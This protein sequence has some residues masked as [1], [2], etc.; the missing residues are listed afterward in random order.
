[1]NGKKT[2]IPFGIFWNGNNSFLGAGG[3]FLIIVPPYR[4]CQILTPLTRQQNTTYKTTSAAVSVYA[5]AA[6]SIY[7]K[8]FY[9]PFSIVK[10][11]QFYTGIIF[12]ASNKNQ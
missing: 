7:R 11:T 6:V 12:S 2:N 8:V 1:M 5:S 3:I 9:V 4:N 10:S